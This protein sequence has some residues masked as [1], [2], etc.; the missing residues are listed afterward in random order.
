[1]EV[2]S[3]RIAA[4]CLCKSPSL[5]ERREMPTSLVIRPTM[6]VSS[7]SSRTRWNTR[8]GIPQRKRGGLRELCCPTGSL[9]TYMLPWESLAYRETRWTSFQND[10]AWH[11][12]RDDSERDGPIVASISNQILTPTSFSA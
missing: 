6:D 7:P 2:G 12:V 11:K 8:V 9:M 3:S 5:S 4:R 1:M 10:P